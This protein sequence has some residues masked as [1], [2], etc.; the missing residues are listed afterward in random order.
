MKPETP[1]TKI[2]R[3]EVLSLALASPLL[4]AV[5][6]IA[7]A[8]GGKVKRLDRQ[9]FVDAPSAVVPVSDSPGIKQVKLSREWNGSL[10]R[11]QLVNR[12]KEAVRIK[13]V[14]IFDLTLSLPTATKL[15][16]EGFQMLSQ[17][18]GTLGQPSDL[19]N[20]TDAKHYKIPAPA[21]A[22][23]FYGLM[24][25]TPP[26]GDT[27]LLAF[28]S[29]RRFNGNSISVMLHCR[30]SWTLKVLNSSQARR[31]SWKRLRLRRARIANSYSLN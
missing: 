31:G 16:G 3:R 11:S 27:L 7:Q 24:T 2:S 18:G 13:E 10:C 15:Y 5:S 6:G 1:T 23:A 20:Y 14:V 25:M 28:T 29:C 30:L 9:S 21:G 17:T 12:G 8:Q 26:E 19:G 22:R 4:A